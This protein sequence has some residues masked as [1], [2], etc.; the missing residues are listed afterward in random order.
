MKGGFA[1]GERA[2][3]SPDSCFPLSLLLTLKYSMLQVGFLSGGA[4]WQLTEGPGKQMNPLS[5][6]D[7]I[8]CI[9]KTGSFS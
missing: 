9:D 2:D 1:C 8:G 3:H 6:R 7:L 5:L 4:F